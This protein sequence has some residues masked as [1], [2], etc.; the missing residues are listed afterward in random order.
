MWTTIQNKQPFCFTL[1]GIRSLFT[2]LFYT[3]DYVIEGKMLILFD[4]TLRNAIP[5]MDGLIENYTIIDCYCVLCCSCGKRIPTKV[6]CASV[7][8]HFSPDIQWL[9]YIVHFNLL[10]SGMSVLSKKLRRWIANGQRRWPISMFIFLIFVSSN[11]VQSLPCRMPS[12]K[13]YSASDYG[14]FI[15][16][17]AVHR[18]FV[19]IK[20]D[21]FG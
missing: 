10:Y 5:A 14:L 21:V 13:S 7:N 20:I 15:A 2:A 18:L 1:I 6:K 12:S 11:S 19:S 3:P 4:D 16:A 9:A 8:M 17:C